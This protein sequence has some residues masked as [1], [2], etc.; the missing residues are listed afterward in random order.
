MLTVNN[1]GELSHHVQCLCLELVQ[2]NEIF[3]YFRP[4]ATSNVC[5]QDNEGMFIIFI[6]III[7]VLMHHYGVYCVVGNFCLQS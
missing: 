1:D 2:Q 6:I 4:Y 3:S 5:V 7:I